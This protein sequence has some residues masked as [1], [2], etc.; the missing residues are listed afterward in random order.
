LDFTQE[1]TSSKLFINRSI[2]S[3]ARTDDV[4][5]AAYADTYLSHAAPIQPAP[6]LRQYVF[7]DAP[8][9]GIEAQ[10]IQ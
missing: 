5:L 1:K 6:V 2:L 3:N 7:H 4:V 8:L 9:D 10:K